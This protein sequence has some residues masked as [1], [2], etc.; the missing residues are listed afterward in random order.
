MTIRKNFWEKHPITE[1]NAA[2]WEALCDGCGA[3]CLIKLQDERDNSETPKVYYTQLACELLDCRTGH[4]GDY[5]NRSQHVPDCLQL[6]PDML[7]EAYWLPS[8][9]GYRRLYEGKPLPNWH[10]LITGNQESVLR[11]GVS[12]AGRCRSEVGVAEA[13]WEK[14]VIRWV[15]R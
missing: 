13:D 10:P 15:Q 2:E 5:A 1:L 7:A 6:T 9:C 12:V 3:C 4:C 11:A 14:Y 8:S